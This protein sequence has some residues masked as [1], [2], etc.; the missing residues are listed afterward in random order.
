MART[1]KGKDGVRKVKEKKRKQVD[2]LRHRKFE[3]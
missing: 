2:K 3:V 1:D